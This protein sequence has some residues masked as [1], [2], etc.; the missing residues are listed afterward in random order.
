[1]SE[2]LKLEPYDI[3][4]LWEMPLHKAKRGYTKRNFREIIEEFINSPCDCCKIHA[5]NDYLTAYTIGINF[6]D[7]VR[8][9]DYGN[10]V[11]VVQRDMEVFLV[12]KSAWEKLNKEDKED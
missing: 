1:M 7:S 9:F 4:K 2:V 3:E 10:T 12:K 5:G 8:R 6:R 11:K